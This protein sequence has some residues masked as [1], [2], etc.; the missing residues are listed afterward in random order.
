MEK[1]KLE[2]YGFL[3]DDTDV[4]EGDLFLVEHHEQLFYMNPLELAKA[5]N[6]MSEDELIQFNNWIRYS[7]DG[8]MNAEIMREK[9]SEL[10]KY[11]N[12]NPRV[13]GEALYRPGYPG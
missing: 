11:L 12:V 1:A 5:I 6:A 9:T 2:Q 3:D 4:T 7:N 10:F 8:G 13:F